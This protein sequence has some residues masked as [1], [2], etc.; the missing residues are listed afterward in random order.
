LSLN[1]NI[2]MKD[3]E[4]KAAAERKSELERLAVQ[5]EADEIFKRNEEQK[6]TRR[7]QEAE[8][9]AQFRVNQAV[10]KYR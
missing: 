3:A 9:V 10:S 4:L 5:R 6:V 1:P 8:T 7:R 2:Q